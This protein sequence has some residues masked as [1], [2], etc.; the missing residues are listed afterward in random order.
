NGGQSVFLKFT[1]SQIVTIVE[2]GLWTASQ[3]LEA[4]IVQ[5]FRLSCGRG[6]KLYV[7]QTPRRVA[8]EL[9]IGFKKTNRVKGP[10]NGAPI[11]F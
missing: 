1:A 10:L 9:D 11:S 3:V 8:E 2:R 7:L 5:S 4:F 6:E